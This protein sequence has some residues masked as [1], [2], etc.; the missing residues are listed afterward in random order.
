MGLLKNT[1]A[2][3]FYTCMGMVICGLVPTM[4]LAQ[5]D[6]KATKETQALYQNLF[7]LRASGTM[8]GHQDALAYGLNKD[9]TRWVGGDNKSDIKTITGEHPGVIGHD[10]GHLELGRS[11]NL[12]EV[13]F[14]KMKQ[15]IYQVYINGG[16]NTLSWHP[17]NPLDLSKTTWDRMDG[18]IR[19][20][21]QDK[22]NLKSFKKTLTGL[23]QFFKSLKGPDGELIPVIFRPY[24]EHT[25]SWF[26]WGADHCTPE[27]YKAFWQMTINHLIKKGKV[28]NL[29]IAY[30]TDNFKSEEH[31][32]ERYPG[33][34]YVDLLGF[35]SYHRNAPMSDSNFIANAKRMVSTL[36]KLGT[37]KNKLY[38]ITETG[39]EQ[40][41][42]TDWWTRIVYPIIQ[43][44]G[45]SYFLVW[46]NGR[47][48]HFY[49]PYEGQS[50]V[51]DFKTFYYLPGTLFEKDVT[52]LYKLK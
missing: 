1:I 18:T 8:L 51:E 2:I 15:S 44:S 33:D 6:R 20:V 12:D 43:D 35:D 28:H 24:H 3:L 42:E 17:N 48:D 25:G 47:P 52:N 13:P 39:L 34:A 50:S 4:A 29:L 30:S 21:L 41:K 10:L 37:E 49:A 46:R 26:W 23:A 45:L 32:L 9:S 40:V 11:Q 16:V 36:K 7:T 14:D 38:A 19:K 27:E 22:K 5:I 31:Y